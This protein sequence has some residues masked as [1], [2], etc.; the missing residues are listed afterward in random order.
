MDSIEPEQRVQKA[1]KNIKKFQDKAM[2]KHERKIILLILKELIQQD[3]LF[4]SDCE[5]SSTI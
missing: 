1:M 5:S 4:T 2:E 3:K